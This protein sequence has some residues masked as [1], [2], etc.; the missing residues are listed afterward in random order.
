MAR[1]NTFINTIFTTTISVAAALGIIAFSWV[2]AALRMIADG[3]SCLPNPVVGI[4]AIFNAKN[5]N[6]LNFLQEVEQHQSNITLPI[7]VDAE[8]KGAGTC[9]QAFI[10]KT[11][12]VAVPCLLFLGVATVAK[13]A[14]DCRKPKVQPIRF[15]EDSDNVESLLGAEAS[16]RH[17]FKDRF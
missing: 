14:S 10:S 6:Y 2:Q 3:L 7:E 16:E 13:I 11:L 17:R 9:E 4:A 1:L 5:F 8:F 15:D 12:Q